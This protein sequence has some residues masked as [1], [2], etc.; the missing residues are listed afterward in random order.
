MVEGTGKLADATQSVRVIPADS[1]LY[2]FVGYAF[3]RRE[4]ACMRIGMLD[5][6][7]VV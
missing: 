5:R 4:A 1:L 2:L 3:Q 6:K 7:S